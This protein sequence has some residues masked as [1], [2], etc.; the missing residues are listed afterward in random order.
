MS[1]FTVLVVPALTDQG[2][3]CRIVEAQGM[4]KAP[5]YAYRQRPE[6]WKEC[7]LMN[8]RG[9]IVWLEVPQ[10]AKEEIKLCEP[11]MAGSQFSYTTG[12]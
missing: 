12:D 5:L 6:L 7:G 10:S 9:R 2:G 3:Q 11:L 8:S 4:F 1:R